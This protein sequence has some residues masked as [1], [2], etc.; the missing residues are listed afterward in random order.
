MLSII[1]V[2][3]NSDETID[4]CLSSVSGLSNNNIEHII[5]DGGS[6]DQTVGA[7]KEYATK[8][9]HLYQIS[10]IS[11]KDEG[12]FDAYNKGISLATNEY[13]IFLNSDDAILKKDFSKLLNCIGSDSSVDVWYGSINFINPND[14]GLYLDSE[15]NIRSMLLK[16]MSFQHPSMIFKRKLFGYIDFD[17]TLRVIGDYDHVLRLVLSKKYVF[18]K[19]GYTT[20][21]MYAGGVSDGNYKLKALEG[22]KSHRK[23]FGIFVSFVFLVSRVTYMALSRIKQQC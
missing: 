2:C 11:E 1:T 22:Y 17:P 16:G 21:T 9:S 18:R 19:H 14:K 6:T 12:I 3:F 8:N 10:W 13:V 23:H 4:R 5:I 20:T 15:F 7:I